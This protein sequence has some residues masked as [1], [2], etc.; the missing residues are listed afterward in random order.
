MDIVTLLLFVIICCIVIAS[1][2]Y[3]QMVTEK[4]I[5]VVGLQRI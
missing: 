4:R 3:L 5:R 1:E 2:Q